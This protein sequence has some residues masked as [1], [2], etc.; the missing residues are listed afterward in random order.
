MKETIATILELGQ[1][2]TN[3]SL[4]V[5]L[6]TA[7]ISRQSFRQDE[8]DSI[9]LSLFQAHVS[10]AGSS[11][12]GLKSPGSRATTR[13]ISACRRGN[14]V[15]RNP[16]KPRDLHYVP[17]GQGQW[18]DTHSAAASTQTVVVPSVRLSL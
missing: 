17:R 8:Y 2:D 10:N 7:L 12:R 16:T 13:R 9:A 4:V 5:V 18:A 15:S 1:D 11:K 14:H 6:R 3:S